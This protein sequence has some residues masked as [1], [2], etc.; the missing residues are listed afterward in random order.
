MK[1]LVVIGTR[2]EVIKTVPLAV[3][4]REIEGFEV[5]ICSTGQHAD[6]MD[7]ALAVFGVKP[8]Y[9]LNV[10]S[11]NQ[12]LSELSAK[13]LIGLQKLII[14][15]KP[16]L[17]VSQGDT[18]TSFTTCLAAFY[19]KI[20]VIHIEAGL[21]TG[22][23]YSPFPEEMSRRVTAM[24]SNINFAPTTR[25]EQ[26]LLNE[27]I[28]EENIVLCGNTG[29]DALFFIKDRIKQD[30]SLEKEV[31]QKFPFLQ[32]DKKL[33]IV[34]AH[35]RENHGEG[36]DNICK[37][38][39]TLVATENIQVLFPIHHNPNSKKHI[40]DELGN[41]PNVF[42]VGQIDYLSFVYL[43]DNS[44]LIITDSG[45]IQEEAPYLGKPVLV[46]RFSTERQEAV[47]IGSSILVGPVHDA[48]VNEAKNLLNNPEYYESKCLT[49]NPFGNGTAVDKI[50]EEIQKMNL[51]TTKENSVNTSFPTPDLVG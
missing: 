10:M 9:N 41:I 4:L 24:I 31:L 8:D 5:A 51:K 50:I 33:V 45:G 1:I 27:N 39:K 44:Y 22:D 37:A 28:P 42:L 12:S 40:E 49:N 35:R 7:Q 25:A 43:L 47:E 20:K 48:I 2:P 34:T 18:A 19:E 29:V 23:I 32:K 26:N 38:I 6:I 30:P 21:R 15:F 17:M 13:I 46:T 3:K 14:E 36:I 11:P 16:D